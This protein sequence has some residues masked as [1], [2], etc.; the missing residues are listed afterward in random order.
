M[1]AGF[2]DRMHDPTEAILGSNVLMQVHEPCIPARD[3]V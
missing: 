2:G 1:Y 3:H